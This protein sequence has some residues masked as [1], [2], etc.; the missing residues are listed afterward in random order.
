MLHPLVDFYKIALHR[1][2]AF[3]SANY[4]AGTLY[5]NIYNSWER[6]HMRG[7]ILKISL[8]LSIRFL[9]NYQNFGNV[10]RQNIFYENLL[11]LL[12]LHINHFYKF[13]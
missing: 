1:W 8:F 6:G 11:K 7:V 12:I 10:E 9:K 5:R 3:G 2:A 13:W 4:Q